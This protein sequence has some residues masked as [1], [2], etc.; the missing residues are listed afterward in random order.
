VFNSVENSL[1]EP[2]AAAAPRPEYCAARDFRP[3][4]SGS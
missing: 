2:F 1:C 4:G 3:F